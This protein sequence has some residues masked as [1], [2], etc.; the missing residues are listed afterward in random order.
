MSTEPDERATPA[1]AKPE[2]ADDVN[3]EVFISGLRNP[4]AAVRGMGMAALLLEAVVLL[5]ALQP[6]RQF[7]PWSDAVALSITGA[8]VVVC[9]AATGFLRRDWGWK[10]GVVVQVAVIAGGVAH[11]SL[12]VLGVL[13]L[14]VWLYVLKVRRTVME[15]GETPR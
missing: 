8:L 1:D 7:S 9:L 10:F 11:W 12:A 2:A 14:A 6:V 5:L 13:F 4:P 15:P 3:P